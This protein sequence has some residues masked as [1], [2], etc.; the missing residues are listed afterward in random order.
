MQM[1]SKISTM[2]GVEPLELVFFIAVGSAVISLFTLAYLIRLRIHEMR[3][4]KEKR[5]H[6]LDKEIFRRRNEVAELLLEQLE[7]VSRHLKTIVATDSLD[8]AEEALRWILSKQQSLNNIGFN[9]RR[10]FGS[11]TSKRYQE[12]LDKI[13]ILGRFND[14]QKTYEIFLLP[15]DES[16]QIIKRLIIKIDSL[17][18]SILQTTDHIR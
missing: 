5:Q 1:V 13:K 17:I 15:R 4:R 10:Y 16:D 7:F 11:N 8:N 3:F 18:E 12:V 14:K 9:I 6:E 2:V